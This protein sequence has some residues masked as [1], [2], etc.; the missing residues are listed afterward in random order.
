MQTLFPAPSGYA[1]PSMWA[2]SSASFLQ[3]PIQYSSKGTA[4]SIIVIV[5]VHAESNVYVK[6]LPGQLTRHIRFNTSLSTLIFVPNEKIAFEMFSELKLSHYA[7]YN[8]RIKYKLNS[9]THPLC[10]VLLQWLSANSWLPNDLCPLSV[11][12]PTPPWHRKRLDVVFIST[13]L[14]TDFPP[15]GSSG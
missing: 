9:I 4:C 14:I 2:H 15:T 13:I 12:S 3:I 7:P 10:L 1:I 8:Y 11:K 5:L 6:S